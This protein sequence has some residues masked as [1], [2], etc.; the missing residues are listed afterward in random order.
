MSV[1]SDPSVRPGTVGQPSAVEV[2]ADQAAFDQLLHSLANEPLLAV[3]TE[4]ASFHR[5]E[6]RVYLLQISSRER[7]A[8]VD[9]LAV[10]SLERFATLL[11][12]PRIEGI[13]IRRL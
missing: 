5:Y 3:D 10:E 13:F 1:H 11:A 8:V 2:V 4:A 6:D 9:P 12:D 7:T